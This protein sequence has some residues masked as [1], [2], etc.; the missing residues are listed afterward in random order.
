MQMINFLRLF[1]I[2]AFRLSFWLLITSNFN[3]SNIILGLVLSSVIPLGTYKSLQLKA[4]LPSVLNVIKIIPNLVTETLQIIRIKRPQDVY[5]IEPMC[6]YTLR[7]SKFAQFIQ[8]VAITS[9][10][11]SI[12]VGKEDDQHWIVHLVGD[13]RKQK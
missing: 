5:K 1:L 12:V 3:I 9:T 4:L 7:G 13:R 8:V 6:E 10:P 11:M 2:L